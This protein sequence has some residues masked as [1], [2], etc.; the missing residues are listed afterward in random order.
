MLHFML[1]SVYFNVTVVSFKLMLY[2]LVSFCVCGYVEMPSELSF[3]LV[4]TN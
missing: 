2:V 4:C 3:L 1:R